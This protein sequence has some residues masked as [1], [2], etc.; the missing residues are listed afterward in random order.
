MFMK[1]EAQHASFTEKASKTPCRSCGHAG[2]MPVLDLGVTAL[3]D[4]LVP[5][6]PGEA[7]ARMMEA[8]QEAEPMA[9][10]THADMQSA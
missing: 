4:T 8:E 1:N 5:A 3:V 2:L 9:E 10:P 6:E 7:T